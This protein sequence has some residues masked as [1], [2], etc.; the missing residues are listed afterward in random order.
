MLASD[1]FKNC[2]DNA[3]KVKNSTLCFSLLNAGKILLFVQFFTLWPPDL[4]GIVYALILMTTDTVINLVPRVSLLCLTVYNDLYLPNW[5]SSSPRFVC[6]IYYSY[7]LGQ[8]GAV[9]RRSSFKLILQPVTYADY[10]GQ[11]W[12]GFSHEKIIAKLKG[13]SKTKTKRYF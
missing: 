8:F 13:T 9:F 10:F 5:L 12:F 3:A 11:L 6:I 2:H 4:H 1:W 7:I